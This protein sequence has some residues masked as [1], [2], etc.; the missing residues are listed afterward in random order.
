MKHD[1]R[2]CDCELVH[3]E[4]AAAARASLPSAVLVDGLSAFF[5]ILGDPTRIRIMCALDCAELCVCDLSAVLGMTKSAV[6]HQLNTLRTAQL[7]KYRRDGKNVYY[8]LDDQHVT[9]ILERAMEH[10][11][12][13]RAKE[14]N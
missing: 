12:H 2:F 3:E 9:D 14:N 10:L 13:S 8:S 7:V 1:D 4:A 11:R 6:S 5:K